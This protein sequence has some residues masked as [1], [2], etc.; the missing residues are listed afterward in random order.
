MIKKIVAFGL[1]HRPIILLALLLF[2][3]GGMIAVSQLNVEAYP[4]PPRDPGNHGAGPGL[5]AEEMERYYTTPMEIAFIR[6]RASPTYGHV[7]L[8]ALVRARHVQ[9]RLI[10]TSRTRS[11]AQPAAEREPA[12]SQV[13]QIQQSSLVGEVYRYQLVGPPHFGLTNLRTVQT[14]W[15]CG[16]S[17]PFRRVAVNSWAAPPR[18]SS[19]GG[20]QQDAAYGITLAR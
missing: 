6:R 19:P 4:N 15:C 13:P 2:V 17:R 9:V 7:L 14:G 16:G 12:A 11:R 18:N 20:P 3:G 8:R 10:S 1:T 5:S